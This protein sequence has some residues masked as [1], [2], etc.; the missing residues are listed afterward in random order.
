LEDSENLEA[1]Q[2]DS[3]A[4]SRFDLYKFKGFDPIER[5]LFEL[6]QTDLS[7]DEVCLSVEG[8]RTR[9]EVI[10]RLD[11]DGWRGGAF[12][13][14]ELLVIATGDLPRV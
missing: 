14:P 3:V 1:P 4:E 8:A 9:P 11:Q 12:L 7:L 2:K 10:E 6:L 5:P 13:T